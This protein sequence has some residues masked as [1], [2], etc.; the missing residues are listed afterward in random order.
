MALPVRRN[1][2]SASWNP[3]RELD[4]LHARMSELREKSV[5]DLGAHALEG[6]VTGG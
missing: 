4:H 6:W 5:G 1:T 3:F 2:E